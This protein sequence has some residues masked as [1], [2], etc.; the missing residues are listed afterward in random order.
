[1]KNRQGRTALYRLYNAE[2]QLLYIGASCDLRARFSQHASTKDWWDQVAKWDSKWL[3]SREEA[4]A[5]E[6][7]AI[8]H[9]RP[10]FNKKIIFV[11]RREPSRVRV[12]KGK[13]ANKAWEIGRA[14]ESGLRR[15]GRTSE[16]AKAEALRWVREYKLAS[17][18]PFVDLGEASQGNA[19]D[20]ELLEKALKFRGA[21]RLLEEVSSEFRI[22]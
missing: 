10:R 22:E 11:P 16:E 7:D 17:G 21:R 1:M 13:V 9:E 2:G 3:P 4:L 14:V 6:R 18:L 12:L 8:M 15:S 5:A 19:P 20:R